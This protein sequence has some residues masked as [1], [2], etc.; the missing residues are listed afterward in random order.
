MTTVRSSAFVN[1]LSFFPYK[2]HGTPKTF[3]DPWGSMDLRLE[4]TGLIQIK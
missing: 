4:T 3:V 2:G 1:L